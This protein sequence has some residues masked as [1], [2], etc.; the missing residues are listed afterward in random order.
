MADPPPKPSPPR[1]LITAG[2]TREP[3][4]AVRFLSNRSSG[5][6]G[7]ALAHAAAD[8]AWEVTLLLGAVDGS[9]ALPPEDADPK[10]PSGPRLSTVRFE[11]T[12]DLQAALAEHFPKA[13]LLVMAAAVSDY[14]PAPGNRPGLSAQP[15]AHASGA[16]GTSGGGAGGRG[17][18]GGKIERG[19]SLTL[20]LEATPDLVAECAT[21][22]QA[23][24]KIVAF[25]LEEP[26]Q[27]LERA[28]AKLERK[29]VDAVVANP[30][31][32][33]GAPD[34]EAALVWPGREP[35]P[36]GARSKTDFARWLTSRLTDAWFA[37]RFA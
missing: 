36:A 29:R 11:S 32:T 12:A 34:I 16:G 28:R 25:A 13:D 20:E 21:A 33:M 31:R 35:E 19:K 27:M 22:K 24:Q 8:A 14:R 17:A 18:S 26:A 37:D 7:L 6:L 4:D 10:G 2:A 3:I 15:P 1:L 23:H 30:L 9:A 5:A